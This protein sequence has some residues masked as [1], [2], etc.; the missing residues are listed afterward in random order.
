MA[1]RKKPLYETA[2]QTIKK[3]FAVFNSTRIY[4][5]FLSHAYQDSDTILGLCYF[6]E[7][8]GYTVYL[9][10]REDPQLSRSNVTKETANIIFD[11][12]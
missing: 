2:Q 6:L 8:A 7:D 4:D 5:V 11:N 12:G 9:D 10:W 3:S 1:Q